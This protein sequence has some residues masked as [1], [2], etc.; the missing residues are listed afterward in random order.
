MGA[1]LLSA[2]RLAVAEGS[3][4]T[5]TVAL[6]S[7]PT[8]DITITL[9]GADGGDADLTVDTDTVT[10]GDQS[11]LTFTSINWSTAQTVTV[12][13]AEDTDALNGSK[14][15]THTATS[16]DSAY[17]GIAI[18]DV[19]ASEADNDANAL[20]LSA[21]TATVV[22]GA[23]ATYTVK[24][25]ALPTA[26]VI[27]TVANRGGRNDDADLTV[28]T[29]TDSTGNQ[30]T[31]TFTTVNWS[32]AQ[33]V[34]LVAAE[35]S[36]PTDGFAAIT[37]T[38]TGG[39]Y[40]GAAASLTATKDDNDAT[41]RSPTSADFYVDVAPSRRT[42][43][44]LN[45]FPFS[46]PDAADRLERIRIVGLPD[47][48]Q[49]TL[50]TLL[51]GIAGGAAVTGCLG[52]LVPV[53]A[54][55]EIANSLRKV[56]YFCPKAGFTGARFEFQVFDT[57]GQASANIYVATLGARPA[58]VSGL[59]AAVGNQQVKLSWTDPD[60]RHIKHY[61]YCWKTAGGY[62]LWTA[63]AGSGAATTSH[64]VTGLT[65]ATAH[66]FQV[67]AISFV[68]ASS[69]LSAE[70]SATPSSSATPAAPTG[71]NV[72]NLGEANLGSCFNI[73]ARSFWNDPGDP[74]ITGYQLEWEA[75]A[76]IWVKPINWTDSNV[77]NSD[78]TTT[79]SGNICVGLATGDFV[80]LQ[81]R[82][83]NSAGA[84]GPWSKTHRTRLHYFGEEVLLTSATPGNGRVRLTWD[85]NSANLVRRLDYFKKFHEI[86]AYIENNKASRAIGTD[87]SQ[88]SHVV[89]GLTYGNGYKYQIRTYIRSLNSFIG[90]PVEHAHIRET[91]ENLRLNQK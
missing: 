73:W 52:N 87:T 5:Y 62:G 40:D 91:L 63:M 86:F 80:G 41:N 10:T 17:D 39:G 4:A 8:A 51:T 89:S 26:A 67:R 16:S 57:Q 3:A 9:G 54:G 65:N 48:G 58:Q 88:R 29:D 55:Q 75:Q 6:K 18:A 28:D 1:A 64:W 83:V 61:E 31:L 2:T 49:G 78:A 43:I 15:I 24:L 35:D 76:G 60:N 13:A 27:V 42:S 22:E 37:H 33:T 50:A 30:S 44:T 71:F 68:G 21:T 82:A 45:A 25:S 84:A 38:A 77:P 47:S 20:V 66:T 34:T 90:V 23:T 11:T 85:A 59:A 70:V 36:D 19:T 32:T 14:T 12:S 7:A 81:L 79:A 72:L 74:S 46:D 69:P 56:L 53:A